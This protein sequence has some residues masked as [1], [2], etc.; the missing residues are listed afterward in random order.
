MAVCTADPHIERVHCLCVGGRWGSR[1]S[2]LAGT[3]SRSSLM[4]R[5]HACGPTGCMRVGRG[6]ATRCTENGPRPSSAHHTF[7]FVFHRLGIGRIAATGCPYAMGSHTKGCTGCAHRSWRA[8]A[9]ARV[10]GSVHGGPSFSHLC[11]RE[12]WGRWGSRLSQLAGTFL[13]HSLTDRLHACG[14]IRCR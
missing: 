4:D 5:L 3:F 11:G 1:L 13:G 10:H 2:Q 6:H 7:F 8:S 12:A 14:P 9:R